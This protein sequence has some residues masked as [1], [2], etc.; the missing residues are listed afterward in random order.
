VPANTETGP[1]QPFGL[2]LVDP[3]GNHYFAASSSLPIANPP[4]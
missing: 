4:Q 1:S 3:A 2:I